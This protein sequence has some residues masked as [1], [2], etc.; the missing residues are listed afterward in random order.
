V[1]ESL[2]CQDPAA[3]VASIWREYSVTRSPELR[4][5]LLVHYLPLVKYSAMRVA[6]RLAGQ[7]DVDD[8]YQS[9]TIGL[10][11]AIASFDPS[12]GVKFETYCTLRI[13][14]AMFDGLKPMD[15]LPREVRRAVH[16]VHDAQRRFRVEYG[17][18]PL[19]EDL[20]AATGNDT[21]SCIR[22]LSAS[23]DTT[24]VSLFEIHGAG[25]DC[26]PV[27]Q[28]VDDRSDTPVDAAQRE[29]L[30]KL[31]LREFTRGERLI[32]TLYYYEEMTMQEIGETLGV[33][34]TRVCQIHGE[35]LK[36]L[37]EK[38]GSRLAA[39]ELLTMK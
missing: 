21:Q 36:R 3:S 14:G 6:S 13:R 28:L 8:L 34:A 27:D 22:F 18:E 9:G 12:R 26:R 24:P 39:E 32:L 31:L 2:V 33:T 4:N 10:R 17:R 23:R 19:P 11:D 35:I 30:K 20:A 38:L 29:D 16:K 5:Q 37:R 7:A 15:P 25:E 1:K